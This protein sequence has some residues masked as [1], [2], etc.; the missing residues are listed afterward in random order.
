MFRATEMRGKAEGKSE[1]LEF[2]PSK[3]GSFPEMFEKGLGTMIESGM[4]ALLRRRGGKLCGSE[5]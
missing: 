5:K 4:A 3:M 1:R 2:L